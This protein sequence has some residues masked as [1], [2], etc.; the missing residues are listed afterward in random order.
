VLNEEENKQ[1]N[2]TINLILGLLE[3]QGL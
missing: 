1:E 2:H 3:R